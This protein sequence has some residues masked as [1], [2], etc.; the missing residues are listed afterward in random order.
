MRLCV[1]VECRR[2]SNGGN[3]PHNWRGTH[4]RTRTS[5]FSIERLIGLFCNEF[6]RSAYGRTQS[7]AMK[8]GASTI[9]HSLLS[10]E[11][12]SKGWDGRKQPRIPDSVS[13][14]TFECNHMDVSLG[15]DVLCEL[16][17]D[18]TTWCN[19]SPSKRGLAA[20]AWRLAV[21]KNGD[22]SRMSLAW[23]SL[24]VEVGWIPHDVLEKKTYLLYKVTAFW[25]K[26]STVVKLGS[27]A[28]ARYVVRMDHSAVL[29]ILIAIEDIE[30]WWAIV[31]RVLPQSERPDGLLADFIG[32][33][34]ETVDF[35]HKLL[36]ADGAR[37]FTRVY[38]SQEAATCGAHI[39]LPRH[40]W[41][42]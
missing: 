5:H 35:Q 11:P 22:W 36:N 6:A 41:C 28:D 13:K 34:L 21:E 4:L 31:L 8:L 39:V 10:L 12:S 40:R 30:N 7:S 1:N 29:D 15:T 9:W 3:W 37:N 25:L 17:T 16:P 2:S 18:R 26:V 14:T 42:H 27:N 38:V 32:I 19:A 20:S 24:L 23:Q 33:I